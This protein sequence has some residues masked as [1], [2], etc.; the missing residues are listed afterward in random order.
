M[1]VKIK[2]KVPFTLA[3]LKINYS[4]IDLKKKYFAK[5]EKVQN[6]DEQNQKGTKQLKRCSMFTDGGLNIVKMSV[7]LNLTCRFN[8]IKILA[9]ILWI[10]TSWL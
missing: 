2:N 9:I 7:L 5:W 4:S 3:S 10:L 8:A 1:E 6:C